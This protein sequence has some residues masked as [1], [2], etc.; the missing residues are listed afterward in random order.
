MTHAPYS[1]Y[2]DHVPGETRCAVLQDD[3][4]VELH[5]DRTDFANDM[6]AQE[7]NIYLGR[8]INVVP[9]LQAAFVDIGCGINGF[10]PVSATFDQ[11]ISK[12]VHVGQALTVQVHKVGQGDKGPQ[13]TCKLDLMGNHVVLTPNR[14]GTNVSR[15]FKDQDKRQAFRDSLQSLVPK[16]VGL[17]VRTS[18]E[19]L[20]TGR[21]SDEVSRLLKLWEAIDTKQASLDAPSLLH[22]E[23]PF[24]LRM[25]DSLS[26]MEVESITIEG[27]DALQT[28]K[29]VTDLAVPHSD[30]TPLFESV[31]IEDQIEAALSTR[32]PLPQGGNIDIERTSAL[33][34]IDVNMGQRL[35]GRNTDDNHL[36]TNLA[37]IQTLKE[38]LVLRNLSGQIL[39]DFISLRKTGQQ[40]QLLDAV[41]NHFKDDVRTTVHG[42]SKLGLCELTRSRVGFSLDELHLRSKDVTPTTQSAFFTMVRALQKGGAK[43]HVHVGPRLH[44]LCES[45]SAKVTWS[46]LTERLGYHIPVHKDLDL[47]DTAFVIEKE[48]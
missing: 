6:G 41:R 11:D 12:A 2:I 4:L 21:L 7:G 26:K 30:S 1:I 17:V 24:L 29:T 35:E 31:G 3:R 15:K 22:I 39:I 32:I 27:I 47:A 10:L 42:F 28:L 19:D 46:W 38:Q 13:L 44:S 25:W 16:G 23:K 37:S 40:A 5:V 18:A 9:S 8:V 48:D 20:S 45:N 34:A 36:R 43:L 33:I 14:P